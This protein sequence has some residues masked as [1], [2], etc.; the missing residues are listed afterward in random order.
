QLL[1]DGHDLF[2]E[3]SPHPV[4]LPAVQQTLQHAGGDGLAL[5]SLRRNEAER[6]TLLQVLGE[7]YATGCPV[8]WRQL[9][10]R[11]RFVRIP[12][13][14]WQ[15][16]RFWLDAAAPGRRV[17]RSANAHPLL[18]D[19]VRSATG[20]HLWN[21]E[22]STE[23]LPYLADHRVRGRAMLPAAAYLEMALAA[24]EAAGL[25][26]AALEDF[27]L[28]EAIFPGDGAAAPT[29]QVEMEPDS[30]QAATITFFS[31]SADAANGAPWIRSATGRI[32]RGLSDADSP[33][34]PVNLPQTSGA[35][36]T[37]H[38]RELAERGLEYGPS[39]QGVQE[40]WREAGVVL[41]RLRLPDSDADGVSS[42]RV[43]PAL[44]DCCLQLLLQTVDRAVDADA[45]HLP[46]AIRRLR[47]HRR[48]E[49]NEPLWGR[50]LRHAGSEQFE[51]DVILLD[52]G[53][54]P[55]LSLEGVHFHRL[56]REGDAALDEW[57]YRIRW[58]RQPLT[59]VASA[60]DAPGSWILL[61][62]SRG[63]GDRLAARLEEAGDLCI[64]VHP[65]A[66]GA[67]DHRG[68]ITSAQRA[69]RPLRGIV[70]LWSLDS[71]PT[72]SEALES[73]QRRG[74]LSVLQLVQA[75]TAEDAERVPR[76]AL[77]TCGAQPVGAASG[78]PALGHAP[79]WGM[80]A[81]LNQEHPE[82][83]CVCVDLD[84]A[85]PL[86][87]VEPLLAELLSGDP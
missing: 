36:A 20:A 2:L 33:S 45:T 40:I 63:V 27:R 29:L 62:D 9:Y 15:R 42:Y 54:R 85:D 81:V 51:G 18:G 3:V 59:R 55:V 76:L 43:H 82:L 39:F 83:G 52:E 68:V 5:G 38:Y 48:P 69:G 41:A 11:G 64:R 46:I 19:A 13:Y 86:S 14:P 53:G 60:P 56:S 22:V 17:R 1:R 71:P 78:V 16:E 49:A 32:I 58:E 57:L 73:A 84:A 28:E 6:E 21:R 30:V 24:A 25:E 65:G 70:H 37:E 61:A 35:P 50:A 10:P 47:L 79:L 72:E 23:L 7:L 77:V 8:A 26:A 75:L 44:L 31:R 67:E 87:G 34:T 74:T 12:T 80:A 66:A 4:L